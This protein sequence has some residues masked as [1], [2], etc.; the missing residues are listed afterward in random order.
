MHS[1]MLKQSLSETA[2]TE[3]FSEIKALTDAPT[4]AVAVSIYMRRHGFFMTGLF[5]MAQQIQ[6]AL[7]RQVGGRLFIH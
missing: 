1:Q 4:D 3:L 7:Y 5:H 2:S 6:L